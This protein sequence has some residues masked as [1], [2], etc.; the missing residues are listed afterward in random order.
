MP[1]KTRKVSKDRK[2]PSDSATAFPEGTIKI[3]NDGNEWVTK[4]SSSGSP[5]WIP[6]ISAELNGFKRLTVDHAAKHIGKPII[7]YCSEYKDMWPKKNDWV[8]K[9]DSTYY[10]MKFVANG[11]ALKGKTKIE[12]WLRT[13]TP[14]VKKGTQFS[15][16]GPTYMCPTPKCDE[17]LADGL[18][19]DSTSGKSLSPQLMNTVCYIKA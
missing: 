12:G 3:G 17:H 16:D 18:Q 19:V 15:L 4:K 9:P 7:L 10:T 11:D 1:G 2:G 8:Q 14:K 5:R 13:Q 6:A